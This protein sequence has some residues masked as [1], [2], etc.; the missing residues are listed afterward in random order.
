[1]YDKRD[2]LLPVVLETQPLVIL[3]RQPDRAVVHLPAIHRVSLQ[4]LLKLK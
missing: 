4:I 2:T 3:A 1:M